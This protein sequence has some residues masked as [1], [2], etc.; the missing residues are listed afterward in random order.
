MAR[1]IDVFDKARKIASDLGRE[2]TSSDAVLDR[3]EY[4]ARCRDAGID[5]DLIDSAS[6]EYEYE[7]A[8]D[9]LFV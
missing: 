6:A 3:D 4:E 5:P 9:A 7:D 8:R 2:A 1:K